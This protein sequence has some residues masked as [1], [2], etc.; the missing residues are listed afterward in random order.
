MR[1]RAVVALAVLA[2][3]MLP[4]GSP[5]EVFYRRE[6]ALRL[7]FPE[8]ERIQERTLL[9]DAAQ[10]KRVEQ[11]AQAELTSLLITVYVGLR[12]NKA[13][14]YAFIES[15]I[16]RTLPG[17]FLIVVS[18]AGTVENIE[19]LAFHES[20]EYLP[21][22]PWLGQFKGKQLGP[23]LRLHA[24]IN[25]IAGSTLSSEAVTSSVRRALALWEV[26]LKGKE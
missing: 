3:L 20:S 22:K 19:V 6:Q 8:A 9:V 24:E 5:A 1:A 17:A 4:V 11:L 23:G 12:D 25:G 16:V 2:M 14:G 26:L 15:P 18:P 10:T 7:A 13:V 21:M